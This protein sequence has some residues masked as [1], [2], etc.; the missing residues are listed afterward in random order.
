MLFD[1]YDSQGN[2]ICLPCTPGGENAAQVVSGD[3]EAVQK[4]V[5]FF[6]ER[7]LCVVGGLYL[8]GWRG[9]DLWKGALAGTAAVEVFVLGYSLARKRG[10]R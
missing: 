4:E 6:L 3:A 5:F 9:D 7:G 8:F 2:K 10:L 1:Y